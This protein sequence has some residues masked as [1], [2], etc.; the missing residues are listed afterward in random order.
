MLVTTT[1]Q[2]AGKSYE[3][4]GLAR[5][6]TI[7]C[8]NVGRDITQG[9]KQLVGREYGRGCCRLHALYDLRHYAGR[10]RGAGVW[11]SGKMDGCVRTEKAL[12]KGR[13]L[14]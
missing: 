4:L 9:L 13:V 7:Q 1:E 8:K 2:I 5:G 14:P 3:I 10:C 11:H 6:S 12:Q